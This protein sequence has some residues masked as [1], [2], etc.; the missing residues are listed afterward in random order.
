MDKT[1][2]VE[3]QMEERWI[4]HFLSM[5]KKMEHNGDIG[6]SGTIAF[7]ADGDGDFRPKFNFSV[8]FEKV[9]PLFGNGGKHEFKYLDAF[10]DAG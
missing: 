1:F 5:L 4:P 9:A 6:H 3:V 8:P 7:Y 10:Y 2:T